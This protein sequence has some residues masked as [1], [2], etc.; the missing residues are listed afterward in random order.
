M[1]LKLIPQPSFYLI[2]QETVA[3]HHPYFCCQC[4][5]DIFS[6]VISIVFYPSFDCFF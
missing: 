5:D 2:R 6:G 3:I 4:E 1:A